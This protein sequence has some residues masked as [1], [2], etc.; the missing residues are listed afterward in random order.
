MSIP[1]PFTSSIPYLF[2]LVLLLSCDSGN[3][4]ETVFYE[5]PLNSVAC[6]IPQEEIRDGGVGQ[7]IIPALT[8][9]SM[10]T[11]DEATYLVDEDRVLGFIIDGQPYAIPLNVMWYHEL[12]NLNWP[13]VQLALSYCPFTGTGMAFDR[14]AIN[15]NEFGVSGLL[16]NNNLIMFDRTVN[17]SLWPQMSRRADCGPS[18]GIA[19]DMYPIIELR[20]G[21]WKAFYP[22]TL[23]MSN[24]T[25]WAI[26]YGIN[27]YPFGDYERPENDALLFEMEIDDRRLPKERV[28]GIP[29]NRL[30][31]IVFPYVELDNGEPVNA[32]LAKIPTGEAVIFW[33]GAAQGAMAFYPDLDGRELNFEVRNDVIVDLETGSTW[34]MDGLAIDG[35]LAGSRL[36]PIA[37]AYVAFWFA[38]AA[39]HPE[40][41]IWARNG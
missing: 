30:G 23:V 25:G 40:T 35:A 29:D 24:D 12:L 5:G 26:R 15:G 17:E 6:S 11:A 39:F 10:F 31:G 38:W 20:W 18:L 37:E 9:P 21:Q 8:D 2:F 4:E 13:S 27:N 16:F 19:L 33:D 14:K 7:D 34:Q 1:S 36:T 41:N 32:V 3:D 22:E 28:L